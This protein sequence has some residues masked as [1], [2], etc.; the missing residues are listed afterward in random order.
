MVEI[1]NYLLYLII[2]IF[3]VNRFLT[4]FQQNH[5]HL[6]FYLNSY[7]YFHY[8]DLLLFGSL[9]QNLIVKYLL[10]LF[11][12]IMLIKEKYIVKLKITARIKRIY[13]ILLMLIIIHIV[14]LESNYFLILNFI[15]FTS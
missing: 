1:I 4:F 11:Y 9:I 15:L 13:I 10:L 7:K 6:N 8:Y 12:F 2:S 5:Y 14:F 3:I